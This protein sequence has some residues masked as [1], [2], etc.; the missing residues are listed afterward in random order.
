MVAPA[1]NEVY[2]CDPGTIE[3]T[4]PLGLRPNLNDQCT[5]L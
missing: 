5:P 3:V 1:D 2:Y 4:A